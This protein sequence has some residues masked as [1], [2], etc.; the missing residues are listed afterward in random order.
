MFGGE[1]KQAWK[2]KLTDEQVGPEEAA[3]GVG[4]L[5]LGRR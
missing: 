2:R 5:S 3:G 1:V 4:I